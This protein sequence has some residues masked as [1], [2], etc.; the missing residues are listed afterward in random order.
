MKA[1]ASFPCS[2]SN[3]TRMRKSSAKLFTTPCKADAAVSTIVADTGNPVFHASNG[4]KEARCTRFSH[5]RIAIS[6]RFKRRCGLNIL[7]PFAL[8]S[9]SC[10]PA[11]NRK[12]KAKLKRQMKQPT[13]QTGY[14][15]DKSTLVSLP[16]GEEILAKSAYWLPRNR[17]FAIAKGAEREPAL[18]INRV[19]DMCNVWFIWMDN[20]LHGQFRFERE[21]LKAARK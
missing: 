4:S 14:G 6:D 15:P 8:L 17:S 13:L 5:Q 2:S 10:N 12:N 11:W 18:L 16:N 19:N 7:P 21:A 3:Q 20:A 9:G 1:S